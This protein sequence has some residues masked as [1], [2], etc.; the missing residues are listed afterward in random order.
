ML[1]SPEF[2][3][4][5]HFGKKFGQDSDD[6]GTFP[7]MLQNAVD[8]DGKNT[9]PSK[10]KAIKNLF[11]QLIIAN[12]PIKKGAVIKKAVLNHVSGGLAATFLIMQEF[13]V[14]YGIMPQNGFPEEKIIARL[15]HHTYMCDGVLASE[16]WNLDF[17]NGLEDE[18][19]RYAMYINLP[20]YHCIRIAI[21]DRARQSIGEY[22]KPD[23][24]LEI[25]K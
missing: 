19:K 18:I 22:A 7:E 5:T 23:D 8:N 15:E 2:V 4:S 1:Y 20:Y 12:Q 14:Q 10:S 13:E 16:D 9:L 11:S 17:D 6:R 24:G 3:Y 25:P 21:L